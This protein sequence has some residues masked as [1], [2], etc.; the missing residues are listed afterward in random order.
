MR[1]RGARL[2]AQRHHWV[3]VVELGVELL[4]LDVGPV[5]K[6]PVEPLLLPAEPVPAPPIELVL[7]EELPVLVSLPLEPLPAVL[8]V[9]GLVPGLVLLLDEVEP[10]PA[11]PSRLLQALRERAAATAMVATAICVR[12][13]FMGE[14]P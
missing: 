13:V 5:V 14:T 8:P 11:V 3:V 1:L 12:D 6:P 2:L 10:V 9:L 7:P 4:G